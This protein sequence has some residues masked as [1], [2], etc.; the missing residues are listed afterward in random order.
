VTTQKSELQLAQLQSFVAPYEKPDWGR[1]IWQ[2]ANS[3]LP[4]IAVW[5]LMY[6][7]LDVS[8][9]ITLLLALPAA[10]FFIRIFIIQHDCGHGSFLPSQRA[11]DFIGRCCGVFTLT[12]Y[13]YWRR[14]HAAHHAT[15]GKLD[16]RAGY[17]I[18]TLTVREYKALSSW[19]RF[20]YRLSRH[21]LLLFGL[22]STIHFALL[23]RL[24]FLPPRT[25][26]RERASIWWT[27][28]GIAAVYGMLIYLLGWRAVVLIQA[29]ITVIAS[30][31]G[32]WLFYVQHQ[33]EDT[34]WQS[35]ATWSF[36]A[37]GMVGSS[38]YKLPAVLQWFTGNIGLHHIHHVSVRVPN[39][40]LQQCL[41]ERPVFSKAPLTL[42]TS[43]RCASL[44]LWDE[45]NERLVPLRKA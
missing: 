33:F 22:G 6:R 36:A 16:H 15:S 10:G 1:A 31:V 25:W 20:K 4:L 40:R 9:A 12:P 30:A 19:S 37:A 35:D 28:V 26:T 5:Y 32:L 8:Y 24:P 45:E 27:N 11:N 21:P 13:R 2:I 3:L 34:Y 14:F 44:K 43:L 23:Q 42:W 38:Y 7:S 18:P 41:D 29:P 39:Y 17:D